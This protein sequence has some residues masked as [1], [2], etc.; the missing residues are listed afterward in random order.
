[1]SNYYKSSNNTNTNLAK[2]Q[3]KQKALNDAYK[4]NKGNWEF[5]FF[6][7]KHNPDSEANIKVSMKPSNGFNPVHI[8]QNCQF[9]SSCATICSVYS[10]NFYKLE[11]FG[12]KIG[13][14]DNASRFYASS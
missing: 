11:I 4:L 12:A 7:K 5:S 14:S 9:L 13:T 2:K 3:A 8:K 6:M 10:F 1:M